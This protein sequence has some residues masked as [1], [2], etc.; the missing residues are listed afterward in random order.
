MKTLD[1]VVIDVREFDEYEAEHIPGSLHRPLAQFQGETQKILQEI[2]ADSEIIIMCRRGPRAEIALKHAL[3]TGLIEGSRISVFKGGI[4][5]WKKQGRTLHSKNA[6][7][8]PIMR[9]VQIVAG[10][11]VGVSIALGYYVNPA[12]LAI[13]AFVG[14]GLAF[15]GITGF[16]GMAVLLGYAPWNRVQKNLN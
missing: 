14:L 16:C 10:S 13:G 1:Q 12:Y 7:H 6:S 3:K 2:A 4:L 9:Q 15:A 5:E 11:L 8:F